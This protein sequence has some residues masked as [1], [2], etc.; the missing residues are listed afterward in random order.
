MTWR[1]LNAARPTTQARE[2]A[3]F[4]EFAEAVYE[5]VR[6]VPKGRVLPYGG[7]AALLGRP[8]SARAVGTA[9]RSLPSDSGV[10]WWRI[11]N[12]SGR[13]TTPKVHH[14]ASAQRQLLVD[15]NVP[16]RSETRVDMD[17]AS[18]T[19]TPRE[20]EAFRCLLESPADRIRMLRR[21]E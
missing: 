18:W 4:V 13:I 1:Y 8:R 20:V 16:F 10:P 15:E 12:H 5:V 19:P 7:V 6:A 11:V 17:R 21:I 3:A 14:I 2:E 9:M